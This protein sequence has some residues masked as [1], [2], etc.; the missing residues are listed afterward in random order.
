[1]AKGVR[2]PTSRKAGHLGMFSQIELM[3]ARG[4]N[5]DI[6]TQAE[7]IVPF[8]FRDDLRRFTCASYVAELAIRFSQEEED[9]AALYELVAQGLTWCMQEGDLDLWMRFFELCLL[10]ISGYQPELYDCVLCLSSLEPVVNRFSA[11]HG[12]MVCPA[13]GIDQA[14]MRMVSLGAFKVLRYLSTQETD[15]VRQLRIREETHV[16]LESL[17]QHYLQY[18]LERELKSPVFM[19]R[20]RREPFMLHPQ[21]LEPSA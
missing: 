19:R 9:N 18:I 10:S 3:L 1:L 12:G 8:E 4:R 13:C 6:I 2:R 14:Q 11:E 21:S 20:L 16:E 17:L 5:F 15:T 7:C